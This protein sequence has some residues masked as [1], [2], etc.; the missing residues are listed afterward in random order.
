MHNKS[1]PRPIRKV[2]RV[3]IKQPRTAS[4]RKT[5]TTDIDEFI[6]SDTPL[7]HSER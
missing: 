5:P 6:F 7:R 4:D 2:R 3:E 1:I